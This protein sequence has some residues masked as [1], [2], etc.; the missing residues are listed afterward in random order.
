MR[1][2]V[3]ALYAEWWRLSRSLALTGVSASLR[4]LFALS[5]G[6]AAAARVLSSMGQWPTMGMKARS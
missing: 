6:R 1:L 5:A 3:G 2:F 4:R